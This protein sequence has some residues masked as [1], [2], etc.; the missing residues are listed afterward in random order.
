MVRLAPLYKTGVMES[1]RGID[2]IL[3]HIVKGGKP[4]GLFYHTTG[5]V[6]PMRL[7]KTG[8]ARDNLTLNIFQKL[9]IHRL[10]RQ[11]GKIFT[12]GCEN[13]FKILLAVGGKDKTSLIQTEPLSIEAARESTGL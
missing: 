3:I 9:L 5:M 2:H 13:V 6:L 7:V 8:V 10:I 1:R 11:F 12:D 4:Q